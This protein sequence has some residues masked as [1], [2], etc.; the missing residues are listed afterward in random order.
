TTGNTATVTTSG[1]I[2]A[3]SPV[4]V[5]S[6]IKTDSATYIIGSDITV[7]VTLKDNDGNPVTGQQAALTPTSVTVP[8]ATPKEGSGWTDNEDGT[9][10]ATYTAETASTEN[11]ASLKLNGWSDSRTSDKYAIT[12]VVKEVKDITVNGYTFAKDAG[13]PTTGFTGATFTL[14]TENGSAAD[15]TWET[16]ASWVSVNSGVVTFTGKG[17]GDKV[18]IIGTPVSGEEYTVEYSF[19][20]HT[21]FDPSGGR[22]P[23][24]PK[25]NSWTAAQKQCAALPGKT[26]LPSSQ[27]VSRGS[28]VR[29]V[30]SLWSEYG[31]PFDYGESGFEGTGQDAHWLVEYGG[32]TVDG[33]DYG[34]HWVPASGWLAK[35]DKFC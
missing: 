23:N 30:G 25:F 16:N 32:T 6:G 15:Y 1:P 28:F 2:T 8:N 24:N 3:G 10:R 18:S 9:Y 4:Q 19:T 13:F 31:S 14:N 29:G 33:S 11:Q 21:W 20:L 34:K 17:T 27:Q 5:N 7:T 12:K 35:G 22:G 26:S